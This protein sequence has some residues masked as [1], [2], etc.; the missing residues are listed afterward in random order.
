LPPWQTG[1]GLVG[2]GSAW[3]TPLC[4][5]PSSAKHVKGWD[6]AGGVKHGAGVMRL[7]PSRTVDRRIL[8][9]GDV[10]CTDNAYTGRAG[11]GP[12]TL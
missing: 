3:V 5:L 4:I 7:W 10:L 9:T 2:G 8:F 11:P 12:F 6:G 1:L